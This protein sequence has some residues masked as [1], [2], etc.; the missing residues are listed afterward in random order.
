MTVRMDCHKGSTEACALGF[1]VGRFG[2]GY[3][4]SPLQVRVNVRPNY[5]DITCI[6]TNGW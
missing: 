4:Q 2:I 3:V 1:S 6:A 5:D